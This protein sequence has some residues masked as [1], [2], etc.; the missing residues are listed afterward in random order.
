MV[1]THMSFS[2]FV[3]SSSTAGHHLR[4]LG[5]K[6][7]GGSAEDSTPNFHNRNTGRYVKFFLVSFGSSTRGCTHPALDVQKNA[8]FPPSLDAS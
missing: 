1:K 8:W 3:P 4:F 6:D 2:P 5:E 7:E